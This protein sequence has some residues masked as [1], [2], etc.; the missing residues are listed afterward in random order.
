MRRHLVTV[1][2]TKPGRK[3]SKTHIGEINAPDE[4]EALRH[5]MNRCKPGGE[6]AR[7]F[8]GATFADFQV[9][10]LYGKP[11]V[12]RPRVVSRDLEGCA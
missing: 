2:V 6:F 10:P 5:L 11:V 8:P 7:K 1:R 12:P 3:F 4:A 9:T